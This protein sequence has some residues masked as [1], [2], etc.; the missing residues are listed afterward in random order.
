MP[1]RQAHVVS[2][3]GTAETGLYSLLDFLQTPRPMIV[4]VLAEATAVFRKFLRPQQWAYAKLS[5]CALQAGPCGS[6]LLGQL[7]RGCIHF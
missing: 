2:V 3:S 4:L 1:F 5:M 7:R 6:Q